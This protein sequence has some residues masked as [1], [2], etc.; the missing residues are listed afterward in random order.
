VTDLVLI[1]GCAP[2]EVG[3]SFLIPW[4]G[5]PVRLRAAEAAA[6]AVCCCI[7]LP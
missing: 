1:V 4:Q 3:H 5:R 6:V 2:K 7:A